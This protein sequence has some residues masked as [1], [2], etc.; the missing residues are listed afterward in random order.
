MGWKALK[1]HFGIKHIVHVTKEGVCIGSSYVNSLAT[2]DVSTGV[3]SDHETFPGFLVE[4]YPA[5][6]SASPRDVLALLEQVDN[7][8]RDLP[9]FEVCDTQIIEHYCEQ[10]GFPNVTHDGYLMY[11]NQHYSTRQEALDGA[12]DNEARMIRSLVERIDLSK[13]ALVDL[14]QRKAQA[15][16]RLTVLNRRVRQG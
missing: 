12:L 11:E 1:E 2:I 3:A 10:Y 6:A 14:K 13:E 16:Q 15:E 8:E 7:F 9:V 5:L 4:H